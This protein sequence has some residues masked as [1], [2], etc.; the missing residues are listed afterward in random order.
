M[1]KFVTFLYK[2]TSKIAWHDVK[3]KK[4]EELSSIAGIFGMHHIKSISMGIVFENNIKQTGYYVQL[5]VSQ[6]YP[7]EAISAQSAIVFT[8]LK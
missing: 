4:R 7:L 3:S 2:I 1:E 5:R 8:Q 6:F